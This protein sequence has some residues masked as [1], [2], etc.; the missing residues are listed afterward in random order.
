MLG[1]AASWRWEAWGVMH[2]A[3]QGVRTASARSGSSPGRQWL[4]CMGT[5]T[6]MH[7]KEGESRTPR[8]GSC[9]Y[10]LQRPKG[11]K[12]LVKKNRSKSLGLFLLPMEPRTGQKLE[13]HELHT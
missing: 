9:F 13:E 11:R 3:P 2:P 1:R 8:V 10:L 6:R 12:A 5:A 7:K 4:P